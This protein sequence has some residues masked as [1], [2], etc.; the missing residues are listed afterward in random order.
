MEGYQT[1]VGPQNSKTSLSAS[2]DSEIPCR[3]RCRFGGWGVG[4]WTIPH[5]SS[6][7]HPRIYLS[8]QQ[9]THRLSTTKLFIS[10]RVQLHW[11]FARCL[12]T[13]RDSTTT[14]KRRRRPLRRCSY[15]P[16]LLVGHLPIYPKSPLLQ[17]RPPKHPISSFRLLIVPPHWHLSSLPLHRQ[18]RL[19]RF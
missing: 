16:R 6:S 5:V 8:I 14:R 7:H 15:R 11:S 12:S 1:A 9:L 18:Q 3:K 4:E 17:L 10:E 19:R 13:S 2:R